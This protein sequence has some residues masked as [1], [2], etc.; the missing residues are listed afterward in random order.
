VPMQS[1]G[2]GYVAVGVS[3]C[4]DRGKHRAL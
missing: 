1:G 3:A 4:A 2:S